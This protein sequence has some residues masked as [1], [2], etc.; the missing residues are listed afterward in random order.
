[1]QA[2]HTPP[3]FHTPPAEHDELASNSDT[4]ISDAK[5]LALLSS[6]TAGKQK[7]AAAATQQIQVGSGHPAELAQRKCGPARAR[8]QSVASRPT[9]ALLQGA[10]KA[11]VNIISSKIEELEKSM[12]GTGT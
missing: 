2:L 4:D 6:P 11:F 3:E 12:G 9:S 10:S 8:D 1:M 5:P 7:P